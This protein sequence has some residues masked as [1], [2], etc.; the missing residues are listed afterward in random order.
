MAERLFA[1]ATRN[2]AHALAVPTGEFVAGALA[3]GFTVDLDDLSIAGHAPE[4]LLP[5]V[6][7][8]L[9]RSAI[10]D[11]VVGGRR[12]VSEQQHPL[13]DEIVARYREVYA[14]VWNGRGA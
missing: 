1:C 11:V 13:R 2:G 10:R 5:I 7:F 14:R 4:D 6:V 9:Q 12:V 8:S 3:D